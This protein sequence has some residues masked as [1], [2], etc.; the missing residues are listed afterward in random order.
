MKTKENQKKKIV[1][2]THMYSSSSSWVFLIFS[3]FLT[4]GYTHFSALSLESR[5]QTWH[6]TPKYFSKY[7]LRKRT[8]FYN[9]DTSVA[10]KRLFISYTI[11]IVPIGFF[12]FFFDPGYSQLPLG[13]NCH[14]LL[15][16]FNLRSPSAFL[17][18]LLKS[19]LLLKWHIKSIDILL[20]ST[21]YGD[22]GVE[23]LRRF[24]L[25]FTEVRRESFL[26]WN[27]VGWIFA[28]QWGCCSSSTCDS[29]EANPL[30][31]PQA[32]LCFSPSWLGSCRF[33]A[34]NTFPWLMLLASSLRKLEAVRKST[35]S[36]PASSHLHR[37][38]PLRNC[39][40]LSSSPNPGIFT[41]RS[42][43]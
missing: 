42:S 15:V 40:H 19:L 12:F 41:P 2:W 39:G 11:C 38:T 14:V 16:S 30:T 6:L 29:A 13:V 18:H 31:T 7:V 21:D 37:N 9:H 22:D 1:Q 10:F 33:L 24:W 17:T 3:P 5:L 26:A 4:S 23:I 43:L 32:S 20:K 34:F 27:L 8:S 25:C 28:R 35:F 36:P